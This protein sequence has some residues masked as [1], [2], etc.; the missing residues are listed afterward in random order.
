MTA[1]TAP[2][3]CDEAKT[4]DENG[5]SDVADIVTVSP[6]GNKTENATDVVSK[7]EWMP[8]PVD[9]DGRPF[10]IQVRPVQQCAR[11]QFTRVYFEIK[12]AYA[13]RIRIGEAYITDWVSS[14][15]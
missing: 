4:V 3:I 12:G 10:S 11:W 13:F 5:G 14:S 9:V 2:E 15:H 8:V 1:T 6:D 7:D